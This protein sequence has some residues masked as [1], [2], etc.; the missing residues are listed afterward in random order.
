[1]MAIYQQ[2][3]AEATRRGGE[4]EKRKGAS[5]QIWRSQASSLLILPGFGGWHLFRL[6]IGAFAGIP[7]VTPADALM[8]LS[9]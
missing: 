9:P 7:I 8:R 6:Q 1:M 4:R 5:H 3:S 2:A